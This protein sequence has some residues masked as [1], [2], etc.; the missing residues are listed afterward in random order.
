[1]VATDFVQ[2][3][4]ER[5]GT[6]SR[7]DSDHVRISVTGVSVVTPAPGIELPAQSPDHDTLMDLLPKSHHVVATL[8]ARSALS[9]SDLEWS[10]GTVVDCVLAGVDAATFMATWTAE[11][12]LTAAHQLVTPGTSNDLRVQIEEYEVLSADQRPG[13]PALTVSE[14]LVYA[15]HFYL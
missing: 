13:E 15:D 10:D 9:D 3:P 2:L 11:L 1:M 6:L 7:P 4:P 8:Q 12:P 5:V 14:R